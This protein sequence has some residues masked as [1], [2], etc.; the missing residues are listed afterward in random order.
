MAHGHYG[1]GLIAFHRKQAPDGLDVVVGHPA[2]A[3]PAVGG[4]KGEMLNGYA[5]VMSPWA[6]PL[7]GR[8]QQPAVS[9]MASTYIGAVV[10]QRRS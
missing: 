4:G 3:E 5:K 10:N 6:L 2:R 7:S 9:F 8:T 1:H